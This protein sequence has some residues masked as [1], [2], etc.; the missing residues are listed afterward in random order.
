M[1]LSGRNILLGISGG[2]AAYK[3]A[4]LVRMLK[5]AGA[6]VQVVMTRAAA[7]FVTP[8]T[9]QAL[10]GREVRSDIFD[11]QQESAMG[12]IDLA[13]WADV[14][15]VAP[16]TANFVATLAAGKAAD[17]LGTLVL[18]A[19]VRVIV[20]PA[21]NQAMWSNA[22][23]QQNIKQLQQN[24]IDCWGPASGAQACGEI[25]EGRMLEAQQ[26]FDLLAD[27]FTGGPLQRRHVIVTAGPTHEP[28]DPVRYI[29]N[30]SSGKMGFALAAA[31]AGAGASVDLIAGPVELATPSGVS[32]VDVETAQQMFAAVEQNISHCD[33]FA[34]CAAVADY[35]VENTA[36]HKIKKQHE[37]LTIK[38]LPNVDILAQVAARENA[39]FTLGFA[40][41]T[42]KL[43][44][45]ASAKRIRKGVDMIAANLVGGAQG[46]FAADENALSLLW[47]NGSAQLPMMAKDLLAK[48]LVTLVTERYLQRVAGL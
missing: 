19:D 18:A 5:K 13:R 37:S 47:D 20:A 23:T 17:L 27:F 34:A 29:G 30:R 32:R 40:A 38:L 1:L 31:F 43:H 7:E 28:I 44:E 10:S 42:E 2:I 39:P 48:Q 25:G 8:L 41:E 46:G 6:D 22:A 3:T 26:L 45:H 16:A 35:R 33:I 15:L 4:E 11:R 9:L 14:I 12:H 21:M 24:G 36:Q